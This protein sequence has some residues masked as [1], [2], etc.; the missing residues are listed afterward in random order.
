M[1]KK[2]QK[3]GDEL[4][5]STKQKGV[6]HIPGERASEEFSRMP[7]I[8]NRNKISEKAIFLLCGRKASNSSNKRRVNEDILLL[9]LVSHLFKI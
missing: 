5:S 9:L 3:Q 7:S 1:K 6:S 8:S 4:Y 2:K